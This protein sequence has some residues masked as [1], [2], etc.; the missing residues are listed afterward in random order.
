MHVVRNLV[1]EVRTLCLY[2]FNAPLALEINTFSSVSSLKDITKA[3][4]THKLTS[5]ANIFGTKCNDIFGVTV[6]GILWT[7]CELIRSWFFLSVLRI[8]LIYRK[9]QTLTISL[10][11]T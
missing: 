5:G 8:D 2:L 7:A 6:D 1:S 4:G 11:G 3:S 10:A 9:A